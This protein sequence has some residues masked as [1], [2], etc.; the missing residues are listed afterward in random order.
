MKKQVVTLEQIRIHDPEIWEVETEPGGRVVFKMEATD[1][2]GRWL[3]TDWIDPSEGCP[4]WAEK[5]LESWF[6]VAQECAAEKKA[7]RMALACDR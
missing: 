4:D 5:L 1:P 7:E 2:L 3:V 6:Q